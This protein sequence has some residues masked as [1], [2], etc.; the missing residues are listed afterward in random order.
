MENIMKRPVFVGQEFYL[1]FWKSAVVIVIVPVSLCS[2]NYKFS[3]HPNCIRRSWGDTILVTINKPSAYDRQM[4]CQAA[5]CPLV[6][7]V[8]IDDLY[9]K[10]QHS[11]VCYINGRKLLTVLKSDSWWMTN[12]MHKSFSM[13]L[14]LFTT[15]YMFRAHSAHY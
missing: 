10:M 5:M 9:Y 15:L 11:C 13:C 7:R 14:F 6:V 4:L 3:K 2:L 1:L 12:V 8:K